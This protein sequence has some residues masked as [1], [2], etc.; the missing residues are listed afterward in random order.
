MAGGLQSFLQRIETLIADP[1]KLPIACHLV[2]F[3][4]VFAPDAKEAQSLKAKVYELRHDSEECLMA[5]GIYRAAANEARLELDLPLLDPP[6]Q[7][8]DITRRKKRSKL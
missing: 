8:L 1:E 6:S 2:E 3:A 4:V 5:Q 7:M